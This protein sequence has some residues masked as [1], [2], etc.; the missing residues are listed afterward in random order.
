MQWKKL[1]LLIGICFS[2]S[3]DA[4]QIAGLAEVVTLLPEEIQL[5]AKLDT[6]ADSSSIDARDIEYFTKN[7][8]EWVRFTVV[9]TLDGVPRELE[10]PV[11]RTTRIT[12][13]IPAEKAGNTRPYHQR[14]VIEME[15]CIG[16]YKHVVEVNL[17]DRTNFKYP[18]LMGASALEAFDFLVDVK[19][20]HV[21]PTECTAGTG[22]GYLQEHPYLIILSLLLVITGITFWGYAKL[23]KRKNRV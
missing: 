2:L 4:S 20:K 13:R 3:L 17:F 8:K 22:R 1:G 10:Y 15:V 9:R 23:M 14:P 21:L 16:N 18:F 6:G 11:S 5:N 7:G 12:S 19:N